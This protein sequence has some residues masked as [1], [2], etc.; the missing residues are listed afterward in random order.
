M[1]LVLVLEKH[2][3]ANLM[4][5]IGSGKNCQRRLNLG[6]N[7]DEEQDIYMVLGCLPT[8]QKGPLQCLNAI[9]T[10]RWAPVVKTLLTGIISKQMILKYGWLIKVI[11]IEINS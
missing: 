8:V 10:S 9:P 1:K 5:K 6:G 4:A 2:R 7:F 3:F 11:Y